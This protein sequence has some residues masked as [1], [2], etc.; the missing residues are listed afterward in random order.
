LVAENKIRE[1]KTLVL[2][3]LGSLFVASLMGGMY[4]GVE[5]NQN[6]MREMVGG[7]AS[8]VDSMDA[9]LSGVGGYGTVYSVGLLS[10]C[11]LYAATQVKQ[12]ILKLFFVVASFVFFVYA[13]RAGFSILMIAMFMGFLF[14]AGVFLIPNYGL[15]IT[16]MLI[17]VI[18]LLFFTMYPQIARAFTSPLVMLAEALENPNYTARL[19][20]IIDNI[21]GS[22]GV[23]SSYAMD[24]TGLMWLSWRAF[25]QSPY[26]GVLDSPAAIGGHSFVFDYLAKGGVLY[27]IF[28]PISIFCHIFY[29]KTTVYNLCKKSRLLIGT[30]FMT[31][32]IVCLLNPLES[33]IIYYSFFLILPG[34]TLFYKDSVLN[35]S[36]YR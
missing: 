5:M 3:L 1:I 32:L 35:K 14:Y 24:R 7:A 11:I 25:L 23:G 29:L 22:G 13:F 20:S 12:R 15:N 21:S 28:L 27:F 2:V 33:A 31:V 4:L 16:F 26:V 17:S 19:E 10:P 18:L 34:I 30:Y 36:K 8:N 6:I 9:S